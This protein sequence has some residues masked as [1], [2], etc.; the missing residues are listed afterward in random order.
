MSVPLFGF[1]SAVLPFGGRKKIALAFSG[2]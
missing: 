1:I 2:Q